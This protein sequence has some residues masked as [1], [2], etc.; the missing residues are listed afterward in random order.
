MSSSNCF[1]LTCI[2]VSQE[3][4]QVVWYSHLFH[5]FPHFIVIHTVKGFGIVN[6][7]EVDVFLE[8]SCFFDDPA[9][10]VIT[11]IFAFFL[12]VTEVTSWPHAP[13]PPHCGRSLPGK[14][15]HPGPVMWL[16]LSSGMWV[17]VMGI[18][19][20]LNYFL[21]FLTYWKRPWCW[22]RLK[23]GGEGGITGWGGWM[24]SLTQ[25]TWVWTIFRRWW[26]PGNHGNLQSMGLQRVGHDWPTETNLCL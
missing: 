25:W 17:A 6:K 7:A 2:Q 19:E 18:T 1:F 26:R 4:G 21:S 12:V 8:L 20:D 23:A 13:P 10:V 5:N 22:E 11:D 16:V 24:A 9:D 15:L 14:G 3:A